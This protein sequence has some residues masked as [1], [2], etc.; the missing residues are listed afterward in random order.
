MKELFI[1][2]FFASSLMGCTENPET[3]NM[4]SDERISITYEADTTSVIANPERGWH[5]SFVPPCCDIPPHDINPPHAPLSVQKLQAMRNWEEK[6]TL[7]RDIVKIEQYSGDIPQIRLDQIQADLDAARAA[8]VKSIFRII[9]NYGMKIGE[10]PAH[11][12]NRHLDQL[13]PIIQKNADVIYAVQAGLLGGSG[14]A[15]CD[16]WLIDEDNNNGWSA[17]SSEAIALYRK[18]LAIV[19]ADRFVVL[20]YPRYKYQMAGWSD[21]DKEPILDFPVNAKPIGVDNAFDGS[22]EARLGYH[23]DNFAGDIDHWGFFNAWEEK[24]RNFT[25]ADSRYTLME[26]ELSWTSDFNNEN[27]ASEMKKYHFS[28][29]HCCGNNERNSGENKVYEGWVG[30][31]EAWKKSGQMDVMSRSLGYRFRLI[32]ASIPQRLS[33]TGAFDMNL[34]M[35]NDGWAGIMNPRKVEIVFRNKATG[36]KFVLD[37]DGDGKGNR[38][39]LP[40]P[41]ETKSLSISQSF[42]DDIESGN[43]EL[44]LHLADPYP[45]IHDRPEYSIRLANKG[46]W[47]A[48]T[49]YN[50]LKATVAITN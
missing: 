42:P 13:K 30:P 48:D 41:G 7:Y 32:T 50:F 26:G 3:H 49:G 15:C 2:L 5:F 47:Q 12:I 44:F 33:A 19:P 9:Y 21:S 24:D 29:F 4:L 31:D 27:G 14:E 40:G 36:A 10:A 22:D 39:W 17:L 1:V 23:N 11:V 34:V 18:L 28:T 38:L 16:S 43:Y 25:E 6:V 35:A 37:V 45:S 46:L 20:R 8:G